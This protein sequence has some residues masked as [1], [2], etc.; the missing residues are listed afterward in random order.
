MNLMELK[1]ASQTRKVKNK[2]KIDCRPF[3]MSQFEWR[4]TLNNG[5]LFVV[6]KFN[7]GAIKVKYAETEYELNNTNYMYVA[8]EER[9]MRYLVGDKSEINIDEI[10][11]FLQWK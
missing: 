5:D 6:I 3:R 1:S 9:P 4:G 11:A 2:Y 7:L 8:Q 10:I